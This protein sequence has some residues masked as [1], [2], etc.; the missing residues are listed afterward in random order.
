MRSSTY[1]LLLFT[2]SVG[3][4][5]YACQQQAA[6][7][8]AR[9]AYPADTLHYKAPERFDELVQVPEDEQRNEWQNP[10][11]IID[12]LQPLEGKVVADLGAGTGYFSFLL[13]AEGATVIAIDINKAALDYIREHQQMVQPSSR[14]IECR[15][16]TVSE[17]ALKPNEVEQVLLVNTYPYLQ[18]RVQYLQKLKL[19]M[20]PGTQLMI[21][22]FKDED[23]SFSPA[24]QFRLAARIVLEELKSAG[25]ENIKQDLES[26]QFQYIITARKPK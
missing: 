19:G 5:T 8:V 6:K 25:F 2:L 20:K 11:I 18:D 26:L 12:L 16:T 4:L 23:S 10:D 13:A 9:D 22:D 1:P 14:H 21:V 24:S 7:Q 3:V 15:L 17:T